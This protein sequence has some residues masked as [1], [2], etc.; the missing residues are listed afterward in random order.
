MSIS[1]LGLLTICTATVF[2]Q[3]HDTPGFSFLGRGYDVIQGNPLATDGLGDPGY[4]VHLFE[5]TYDDNKMTTDGHWRIA[6]KTDSETFSVCSTAMQQNMFNSFYTYQQLIKTN[7]D[8]DFHIG[9]KADFSFG[10]DSRNLRNHTD[11]LQE[12][13]AHMTAVCTAYQLSMFTFDMPTLNRDFQTAVKM[14]PEEY[15]QSAYNLMIR[16]FGT[17]YIN[18]MKVGGRWGQQFTFKSDD[19]TA[20]EENEID[21]HFGI[22]AMANADAGGGLHFNSSDQRDTAYA[23]AK[24]VYKNSTYSTGGTFNFDPVQWMTTVKEE[25]MPVHLTLNSLDHL[26][27]TI[28]LPQETNATLLA[29]KA[30]NF[31]Q[32]S[33]DY[34]EYLQAMTPGFTCTAPEPKPWPTPAPIADDAIRRVCVKNEGGYALWWQLVTDGQAGA[35]T[36]VY[37]AGFSQCIDGTDNAAKRGV[38]IGCRVGAI[39]GETVNCGGDWKQYDVHSDLQATYTCTGAYD[40]VKCDLEGISR[41][42][43]LATPNHHAQGEKVVY[44]RPSNHAEM[45]RRRIRRLAGEQAKL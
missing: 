29:K 11:N 26:F 5:W 9:S 36:D 21:I 37:S 23:V 28:W 7:F 6:D 33:A 8:I 14:M 20:L 1:V 43:T 13:Y 2:G 41:I 32:A 22:T 34:C 12:V 31:R 45:E 3:S 42:G 10:I 17:H 18:Q 30:A 35:A 39:A 25:P 27:N 4:R 16:E 38:T 15:D 40:S 44:A 19:Y 24:S